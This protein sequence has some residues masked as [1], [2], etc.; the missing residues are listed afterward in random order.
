MAL[1]G[2]VMMRPLLICLGYEGQDDKNIKGGM[3]IYHTQKDFNTSD[4]EHYTTAFQP[5]SCHA[6]VLSCGRAAD[7]REGLP[8][9]RWQSH[10][11]LFERHEERPGVY[12]S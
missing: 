6:Y 5:A 4:L 9:D 12:V 8:H 11:G 2:I 3:T 7:N 1:L 10:H